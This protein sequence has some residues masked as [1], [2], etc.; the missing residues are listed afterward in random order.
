MKMRAR[1]RSHPRRTVARWSA[2]RYSM[3]EFHK[4]I[5]QARIAMEKALFVP[6]YKQFLNVETT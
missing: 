1:R 2:C 6:I 5:E 3:I 4:A